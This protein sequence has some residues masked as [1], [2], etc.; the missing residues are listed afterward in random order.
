MHH[1]RVLAKDRIQ[2]LEPGAF[3]DALYFQRIALDDVRNPLF[4]LLG[5]VCIQFDAVTKHLGIVG[6]SL[7]GQTIA[8]P[9]VERR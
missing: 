4:G 1:Y 2:K 8:H 5:A 6:D 9:R 3:D 7:K